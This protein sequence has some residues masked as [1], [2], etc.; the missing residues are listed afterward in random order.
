MA[1]KILIID[2]DH[3]LLRLSQMILRRKGYDAVIAISAAEARKVLLEQSGVDLIILDLMMP[4]EDGAE[5]LDWLERQSDNL[6]NTPVI[7]NT[8]KNLSDTETRHF[9]TRCRKIILKGMN[10]TEN[11]ISEVES[12]LMSSSGAKGATA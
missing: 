3:S 7:I 12:V 1:K 9:M 6:K 10:F 5:F 4:E 2:D 11:L 8:A